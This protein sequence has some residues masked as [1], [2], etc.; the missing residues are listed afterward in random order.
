MLN[1]LAVSI[2]IGLAVS[3]L[4]SEIFGIAAGGMIVPGYFALYLLR[5][6]DCILTIGVAFI[7]YLLVLSLSQV[8]IIYGKRRTVVTILIAYILG[9]LLQRLPFSFVDRLSVFASLEGSEISVIGNIIPG[10]I[11]IWIDRQGFVATIAA[12]ITS[13]SIVRLILILIFGTG[14]SI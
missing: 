10:L 13:A 9:A 2:G 12:L 11:A 5:P 6:L 4:L 3:I 1:L 7:T 14:L 8:M